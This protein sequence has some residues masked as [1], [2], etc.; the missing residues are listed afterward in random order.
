MTSSPSEHDNDHESG[1]PAAD[2]AIEFDEAPDELTDELPEELPE[3]QR[4]ESVA[5]DD[6][7]HDASDR[8]H[9]LRMLEALLFASAAPLSTETMAQR[10]PD[11]AD[12]PALLATLRDAYA[13]RGVN[14]VEVA[15][16]WAL[17][18]AP[19]LANILEFERPVMRRLSRAA[20]ETLAII[21]YHQPITRAEIEEVRGRSLSQGTLEILLEIGW[22]KP[23]GRRQTPGRPTTWGTTENFLVQFQLTSLDA[24]PGIDELK[25]AGLLDARPAAVVTGVTAEDILPPAA[26]D[27]EEASVEDALDTG[28]RDEREAD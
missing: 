24:L 17:R 9:Q 18:T 1:R 3:E 21:A 28:E 26:E 10:L 16:K 7:G 4:G 5:P 15:G 11:G 25:A 27:S 19:D 6:L 22:I 2:E 23:I 13:G 20:I 12:I 8:S 14:L